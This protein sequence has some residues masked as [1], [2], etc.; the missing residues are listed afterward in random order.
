MTNLLTVVTKVFSKTLIFLLQ[1]CESH[2][3]TK[4]IDVFLIFQA[5]NVNVSLANNFI[6]F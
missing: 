1:K 6:K 3:S 2:F 4:N 5:K